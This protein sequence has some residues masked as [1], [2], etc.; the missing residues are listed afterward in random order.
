MNNFTFD[1]AAKTENLN[2]TSILR[3]KIYDFKIYGKNSNEPKL[4]QN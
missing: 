1:M 2:S 4:T 3:K